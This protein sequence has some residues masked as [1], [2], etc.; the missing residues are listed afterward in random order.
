MNHPCTV[1]VLALL[2]LILAPRLGAQTYVSDDF[3]RP[4][5]GSNWTV[6]FGGSGVGTINNSDLGLTS[7]P[8]LFGLVEWHHVVFASDQFSEAIIST[9]K[10][11]SI[12]TQV[13]VRRRASDKARYGFHWNDRGGQWEIKYDGVPTAQTRI[14]ASMQGAMP[15][16][17]DTL[18]IEIQGMT[19]TGYH[20]GIA[21]LTATD[22]SP[23]AIVGVGQPGMAFRFTIGFSPVYPAPVF[24]SWGAGDLE[25][26]PSP[27]IPV[28]IRVNTDVTHQQ[29]EGFGATTLSL[30]YGTN[31][32]LSAVQ[33]A[34]AIEKLYN[35]V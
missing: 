12:L 17:G 8:T 25:D 35:Q 24:E 26:I 3:E 5:L 6:L 29:M 9:N 21:T 22:T 20:N 10:A 14:L 19:I 2:L 18:R 30:A 4:T 15:L 11:D 27:A 33:R 34:D 31:D 16:P 7:S 32:Y 23:D 1:S 28:S 13:F